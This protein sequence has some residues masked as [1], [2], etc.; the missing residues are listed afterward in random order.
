MTAGTLRS[1]AYDDV[2]HGRGGAVDR[3]EVGTLVQSAVDG[4]AGAWKALVEGMSP[5]VWSVVRAHRLSDADGHEVY[6]TVWFRFAQH[7][8]RI[9]EP[10]KAGS[11]LA[12]TTRHECLKVLKSL[13][14]LTLTDDPHVLDRAS[15]ER[16]PEQS[17]IEAEEAA[18]RAE[19]VRRLW[20]E[21]DG[22]GERCRQL[23][24][25]LMASP[26]PS[27]GEISAALGIAVGSIGPLR[28]RCLRRLRARMDARG[29]A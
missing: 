29:A 11:W 6:Q 15:E 3:T 20:Q 10:D 5:L 8:G 19:R 13:T 25:V 22:L 7:L 17:L 2:P 4:D 16:T 14:R 9:R 23:L 21:L 27:Y 24:R 26:P 28:Q 12:S 18:D 1:T